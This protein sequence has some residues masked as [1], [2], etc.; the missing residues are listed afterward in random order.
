MRRLV[1]KDCYILMCFLF[2]LHINV[3]LFN[4]ASGCPED[5]QA[6]ACFVFDYLA[7]C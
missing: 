3:F 4:E 5:V 7:T 2:V 6:F 1:E